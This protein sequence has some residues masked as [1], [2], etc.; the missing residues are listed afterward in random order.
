MARVEDYLWPDPG[1]DWLD[2]LAMSE[3]AESML[4]PL[5][6]FRSLVRRWQAAVLLPVDQLVLTLAQDLF[7][8]PTELAL[9]HKLAL[10]LRQASQEHPA[11]RLPELSV[12]LEAIAKNRR[13]LVGFSEDDTGFDPDKYKGKVVVGTIHKAKGLEWDRVYLMSANN[14]DFPSGNLYDRYISERWFIRGKL[15]LEAEG[16]SQ[17][18][19]ALSSDPYAWYREGEATQQARLDY[20]RERLRLFYVGITR[21]RRELVVTW[22]S[23]RGME[24]STASIPFVVLQSFWDEHLKEISQS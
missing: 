2:H 13:K 19:A 10:I 21:A 17:L 16:H 22:N 8:D 14:Y 15:N 9:A 6:A 5:T 24:P 11:W 1:Q 23:G 18:E 4:E 12:E 20:I 3:D 7:T